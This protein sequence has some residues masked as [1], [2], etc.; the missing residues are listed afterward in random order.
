MGPT[1]IAAQVAADTG[2]PSRTARYL[3]IAGFA[4]QGGRVL[5]TLATEGPEPAAKELGVD[6]V[7]DAA[8]IGAGASKLTEDPLEG[9]LSSGPS[10]L[11]SRRTP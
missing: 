1:D 2:T 9:K 10:K 5:Y 6:V 7:A 11:V 4:I 8:G 3:G